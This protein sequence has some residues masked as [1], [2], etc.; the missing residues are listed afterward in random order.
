MKSLA[1]H[2]VRAW[3]KLLSRNT[4]FTKSWEIDKDLFLKGRYA[5]SCLRC[6]K[7][8]LTCIEMDIFIEIWNLVYVPFMSVH[9]LSHFC[10]LNGGYLLVTYLLFSENLLVTKDVLKIAD[11]GLAREVSSMPPYTE[12]VSTRWWVIIQWYYLLYF[13]F[14]IVYVH[15]M[16]VQSYW[17]LH[18]SI[19]LIQD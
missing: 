5:A 4:I 12:Y 19:L 17:L 15:T 2:L 18:N 16:C 9:C 1:I 14:V 8:L 10:T 11:F 13:A 3:I 6:C 7:D